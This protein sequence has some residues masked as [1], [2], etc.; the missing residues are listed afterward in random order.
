MTVVV[1]AIWIPFSGKS[2]RRR[3]R[4][5]KRRRERRK[6]TRSRVEGNTIYNLYIELS[7]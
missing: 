4:P 6:R 5:R 3:G 2:T 1:D 7:I